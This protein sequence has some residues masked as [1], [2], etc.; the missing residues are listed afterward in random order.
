MRGDEAERQ[1]LRMDTVDLVAL[2]LEGPTKGRRPARFE[3]RRDRETVA[4]NLAYRAACSG[5]P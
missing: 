5:T 1:R 3:G 4:R 2:R